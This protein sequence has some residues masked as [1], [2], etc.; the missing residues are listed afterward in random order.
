[1]AHAYTEDQLVEQPAIKLF[2][3]LGWQTISALEETFGADGTLGRETK[4]EVVLVD[5]LRVALTKLNPGVFADAIQTAI[6][7]LARDRS[8]M[9][10]EAANCE[11]YKQLDNF[12]CKKMV[13]ELLETKTDAKREDIDRLLRKKISDAITEEQKTTFIRNLLQEMRREKSIERSGAKT[14]PKAAWRLSSK[15]KNDTV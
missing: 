11:I 7:E 4:G 6:D 9:S 5:R 8:A 2:R 13:L 3:S 15:G 12:Y 10:L 1:M 14:G